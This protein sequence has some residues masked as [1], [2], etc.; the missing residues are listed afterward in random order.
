MFLCT[1]YLWSEWPQQ[2][3]IQ[4]ESRYI[5]PTVDGLKTILDAE[6]LTIDASQ[7]G[8]H[9]ITIFSERKVF[10]DEAL[11]NSYDTTV[12]IYTEDQCGKTDDNFQK[13]ATGHNVYCVIDTFTAENYI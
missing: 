5:N 10:W 6:A 13:I 8:I 11:S 1:T 9:Q 12:N 2:F 3:L 7:E 4:L